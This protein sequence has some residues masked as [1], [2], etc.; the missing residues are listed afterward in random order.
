[1]YNIAVHF[2]VKPEHRD[3]FIAAA[4]EDGRNSAAESVRLISSPSRSICR[5]SANG[6]R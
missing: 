1:M 3:D 2:D 4:L 6:L 5:S